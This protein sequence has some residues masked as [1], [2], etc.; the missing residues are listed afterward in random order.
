MS[1][2]M[3]REQAIAY[4]TGMLEAGGYTEPIKM[5]IAALKFY[6]KA[7]VVISQLRED[8]DRLLKL[9]QEPICPSHGIDCEDCPAYEPREDA[10]SRQAALDYCIRYGKSDTWDYLHN[11]PSVE[12]VRKTG[13]WIGVDE[14]PHEDWECDRCGHIEYADENTPDRFNY[15]PNCGALMIEPQESEEQA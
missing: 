4:F 7:E 12:P 9:E 8:R 10:I 1:E 14:E 2:E 6:D 13:H 5:A 3:T 15:C 11:L